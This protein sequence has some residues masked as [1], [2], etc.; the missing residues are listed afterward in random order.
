MNATNSWNCVAHHRERHAARRDQ[1][2]GL[3]LGAVVWEGPH[4]ITPHD[5]DVHDVPHARLPRRRAHTPANH[6]DKLLP[7]LRRR[8]HVVARPIGAAPQHAPARIGNQRR[9]IGR[10]HV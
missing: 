3:G 4:L 1:R 2:L 10:A 7:P 9:Q 8:L 5:A 6:A